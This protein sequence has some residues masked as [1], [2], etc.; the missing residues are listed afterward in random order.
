MEHSSSFLFFIYRLCWHNGATT[1]LFDRA[2]PHTVNEEKVPRKGT[3]AENVSQLYVFYQ[4]A[5]GFLDLV[6]AFNL[7]TYRHQIF[8]R[9]VER[10]KTYDE[11]NLVLAKPANLA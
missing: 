5:A 6:K 8:R 1:Q 7:Y 10:L 2:S 9:Y 11:R 4:I 3:G